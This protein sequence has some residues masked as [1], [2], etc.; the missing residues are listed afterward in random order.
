MLS[1]VLAQPNVASF[2][3]VSILVHRV[4]NAQQSRTSRGT[5]ESQANLQS[6]RI[7]RSPV[8]S[9]QAEAPGRTRRQRL[10]WGCHAPLETMHDINDTL[11]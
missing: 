9:I 11:Q 5:E 1:F 6:P 2:G 3:C 7:L 4:N 10:R 8:L